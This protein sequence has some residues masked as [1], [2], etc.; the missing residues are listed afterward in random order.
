MRG[1]LYITA[2]KFPAGLLFT[3]V[4][5]IHVFKPCHGVS[6]INLSGQIYI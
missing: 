5:K 6:L 4:I 1:K 2:E 3:T